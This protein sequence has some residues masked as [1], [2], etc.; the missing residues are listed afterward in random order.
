MT[1]RYSRAKGQSRRAGRGQLSSIDV[2]PE[3][4]DEAIAWANMQLRE[5]KMPQQEV[6]RQFNAMLADH[7]IP[8]ITRS[9]FSRYSIRIAI[10]M[11]KME[12]SRQI[13]DAVLSRIA[14]GERSGD[15]IAA[16][17]LVKYRIL[18]Q[19]M[20]EEEPNPKL[21]LN[22]TLALQRLSSIAAREAEGQRREKQDEKQAAEEKALAMAK[23]AKAGKEGGV[24]AETLAVI[25]QALGVV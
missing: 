25:N 14:P 17:E 7:G 10:E 22:A 18:E 9:A 12:A 2:L 4:A 19:V 23:V 16:T 3:E 21:L 15:M 6:L 20:A 8:A 5:R 24:S 1:E 11:R 13:M